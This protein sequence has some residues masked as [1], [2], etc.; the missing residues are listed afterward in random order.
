MTPLKRPYLEQK[1]EH[2]FYDFASVSYNLFEA[3]RFGNL[4]QRKMEA[5]NAPPLLLSK[6]RRGL[7]KCFASM[8][9]HG[10]EDGFTT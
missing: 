4:V 2:I 6:S 10:L 7:N 3:R 1:L 8:H 5:F 9:V